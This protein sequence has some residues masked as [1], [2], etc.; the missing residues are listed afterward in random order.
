MHVARER[1]AHLFVVRLFAV[2]EFFVDSV[3]GPSPQSDEE[4]S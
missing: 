1:M 3:P 2:E 4:K